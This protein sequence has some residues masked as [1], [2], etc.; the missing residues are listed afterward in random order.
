VVQRTRAGALAGDL[1]MSSST[2]SDALHRSRSRDAAH[3]L[4]TVELRAVKSGEAKKSLILLCMGNLVCLRPALV[5]AL[6]N[7]KTAAV[8]FTSREVHSRDNGRKGELP[9]EASCSANVL[10]R[11]QNF[12][13]D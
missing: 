13:Y 9:N 3:M 1:P 10:C 5:G 4:L 8:Y 6:R 11:V 7:F 2:T 12:L